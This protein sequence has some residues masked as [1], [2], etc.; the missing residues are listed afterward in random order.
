MSLETFV[1]MHED[2]GDVR[3]VRLV[4]DA[5]VEGLTRRAEVGI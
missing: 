2:P 5:L 3:R 1:V 4:L